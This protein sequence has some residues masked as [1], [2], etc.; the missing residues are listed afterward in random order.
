MQVGGCGGRP[1]AGA[2]DGGIDRTEPG[3]RYD[4]LD[5]T[6]GPAFQTQI[7]AQQDQITQLLKADPKLFSGL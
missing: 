3:V 5:V 6:A 7:Q 4:S 1:A 2:K